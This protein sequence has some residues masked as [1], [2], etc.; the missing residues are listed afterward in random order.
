MQCEFQLYIVF[1]V[2]IFFQLLFL[3]EMYKI[4]RNFF[5]KKNNICQIVFKSL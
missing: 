4:S 5:C 1:T 3:K 2:L